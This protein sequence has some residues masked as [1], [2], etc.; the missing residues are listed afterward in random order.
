MS[1]SDIEERIHNDDLLDQVRKQEQPFLSILLKDKDCLMDA[2]SY[3]I[4]PE[5]YWDVNCRFLY[6][7]MTKNYQDF[8]SLL[9]RSA[10]DMLMDMA[11]QKGLTDE[12]KAFYKKYWDETYHVDAPREDYE[13]LK[14]SMNDRYLQWQAYQIAEKYAQQIV[15]TTNNQ[16][17][18][19]KKLQDEWQ[20][21]D[22]VDPSTYSKHMTLIEGLDHSMQRIVD[23]RENPDSRAGIMCGIKGLDDIF[24]GFDPGSY[25][26]ITGFIAGGKTTLMF[27]MAFNM[28][29][30]GY[31][32]V[33]VSMEKTAED[34]SAR[35]HFLHAMV[36]FNRLRRGGKGDWGLPDHIH[37]ILEDAYKDL[38]ENIEPKM[39]IL[40]HVRTTKLSK[41]LS[42]IDRIKSRKKV[43]IVV[44]DYLQ[45][46]G[47]EA[48]FH[49]TRPDLDLAKISQRLQSYGE[50]NKF[51]TITALQIK[52]K[53][54]KEIRG[55][56]KKLKTD[57]D[58]QNVKIET[59]DLAG[60]QMVSAD[61]DNVIGVVKD[62][63]DVP[64]VRAIV[65]I[66]KARNA[67]MGQSVSLDFDGK[68]G[69]MSDPDEQSSQTKEVSDMLYKEGLTEEQLKSDDLFTN[70]SKEE[71]EEQE[72]DQ[73]EVQF[74]T[75]VDLDDTPLPQDKKQE[76]VPNSVDD[77][78]DKPDKPPDPP[79]PPSP[80]EE[81]TKPVDKTMNI[82]EVLLDN[83]D[84]EDADRAMGL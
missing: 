73:E 77:E 57:S 2:V 78:L 56:S 55:R 71:Q 60:T 42:D 63:R 17:D 43:H 16:T 59:E 12:K 75:D 83:D 14:K 25:S 13:L 31:N 37:K 80:S 67:E 28:A 62:E 32:V 54:T 53:S 8:S 79:E 19:V 72:E 6:R 70:I 48:P 44:V 38:K 41:I 69:K 84:I 45:A 20:H 66:T 30:M 50:V 4:K 15:H 74:D 7:V 47:F 11:S 10:M 49:P 40:Y 5:H 51:V 34:L 68:I 81:S 36:D 1:V 23:M 82:G 39:D 9:T 21:I 29:K 22:N 35:L 65:S 58:S 76:S 24:M 26:V 52:N 64:V 61:A 18:L 33:Y 46:I 27:N 3:G